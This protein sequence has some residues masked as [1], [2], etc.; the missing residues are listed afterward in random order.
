MTIAEQREGYAHLVIGPL[1]PGYGYTLG[2]ALRRVL[3]S[4]LPGYAPIAVRISGV[5]HPF[6]TIEG[7]KEDV[8]ELCLALKQVRLRSEV[9]H[10]TVIR[11]DVKGKKEVTAAD[12]HTEGGVEIANP[13]LHIAT[14]TDAKSSLA[15]EMR[16]QWGVGYSM[17]S[18]R[19]NEGVGVIQLDSLYS[20][21]IKVA[22]TVE[23][24]RVGQRTDY[25]ELHLKVFTDRT[26]D[27]KSAVEDAAH[28]LVT[29]YARIASIKP[30]EALKEAVDDLGF[31]GEEMLPSE[32]AAAEIALEDTSIPSR[33][34]NALV[35]AGYPTL[36]SLALESKEKVSSVK[37]LG[38]KS[39][40]AVE[41]EMQ[42][43]GLG[44][45]E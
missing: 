36:Q 6:S 19:E 14:L 34:A 17:A 8:V 29:M 33:V 9:E 7:V 15:F 30:E 43:H 16:A 27:P 20:P 2:N 26:I 37:N 11:L 42:K 38:E 10:E 31:E 45:Q 5:T 40:E 25:D 1:E 41:D 35:K 28:A 39:L 13:E 4:S 18:E 32:E 22:Y 24:T 44:F 21:V 23:A 12:L 3:L